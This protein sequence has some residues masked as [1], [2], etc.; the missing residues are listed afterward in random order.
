MKY[1]IAVAF[2]WL[3]CTLAWVVLA[4]TLLY[5][6]GEMSSE[7]TNEVDRLWGPPLVQAPPRATYQQP[8][9]V[10]EKVVT[11]DA[12]G[13]TVE[14]Q[15]ERQIEETL[16]LPLVRS[17]VRVK[18]QLEHRRK[19][20][21]WFPTYGVDF[22]ANYEFQNDTALP[23]AVTALFPLETSNSV[24]DG[25]RISDGAGA[26]RAVTVASDGARFTATLAPGERLAF[27]VRY[28]AR[29]R[30]VWRY[31]LTEGA[32]S[33]DRFRL[34]M[35]TDFP[36]VDFPAGSLS[37][38]KHGVSGS[39]WNGEWRFDSLVAN[40]A[41]GVELPQKLNP[42]PLASRITFF[43]PV[44]LLFFLFVA[45]VLGA[46]RKMTLHPMH[47][48]FIGC[49]FFA[50]HLLF[51][52]T[53]DHIALPAAFLVSSLVSLALVVSYARWFLG[54][55]RALLYL[56]FPQ[57]LYLVLFSATFFWQGFTG[58][59]IVVGA[60]LTLFV[61]MQ[62]VGRVRWDETFQRRPLP[63]RA[64]PLAGASPSPQP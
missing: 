7:L 56:A 16:W 14:Q 22:D 58:L 63:P 54:L 2:V 48:F 18:L 4:S 39:G 12:Q 59:A 42:G 26:A 25:F 37:P 64:P 3:G 50:F 45:S 6:S 23:R 31:S 55:K 36:N 34:A 20:L 43:A 17:D 44:G 15:I 28:R 32:G 60:V 5:R 13:K 8:K 57:F 47:Y 10:A 51:A 40:A 41:L 30:S 11:T 53:V 29:G 9:K 24:Y 49:A 27:G 61:I 1:F 62:I 38:S 46:A 33:V 52:Y 35:T 19:G 21:L